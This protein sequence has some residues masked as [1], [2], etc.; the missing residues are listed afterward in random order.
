V[1][2]QPE[3][4]EN[5]ERDFYHNSQENMSKDIQAS[6]ASESTGLFSMDH[7]GEAMRLASPTGLL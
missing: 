2:T 6:P 5:V 7:K 4:V 1:H 3:N